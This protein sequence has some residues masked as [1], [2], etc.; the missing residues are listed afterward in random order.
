MKDKR[1]QLTE[2]LFDKDA[3]VFEGRQINKISLRSNKSSHQVKMECNGWP[4]FGIWS[5]K[6]CQEFVCLEPWYGIADHE[7]ATGLLNE[8]E[9]MIALSAGVT[10]ECSFSTEFL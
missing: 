1:L 8:K 6:G 3:L 10:F 9:G 7:E 4:Y 5:K 2:N